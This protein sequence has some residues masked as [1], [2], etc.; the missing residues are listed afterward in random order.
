M[1]T[2]PTLSGFYDYRL[3]ALSVLLAMLASYAALDLAGRITAARGSVRSVWRASGAVAMGLGIWSMHYIGM[4]AYSLPV[5][6]LYDWPTVLISL[7]AAIFASYVALGIVSKDKTSA[8]QYT[9]S[10]VLM[11]TGI[12]AMH[13]IGMEAMR[14][15]AMCQYS[16][17]L[18]ILSVALAIGISLAALWLTSRSRRETDSTGWRK[19]LSAI[20]MGAAIPVMHYT[21][22]AAAT[23]VPAAMSGSVAH[24]VEISS[25][26]IVVISSFTTIVLGLTILTSVVDRRFSEQ[27]SKLQQSEERL[28]LTLRSSGVAVWSWD[29][30]SNILIGDENCAIQFGLALGQFPQNIEGF[31]AL[32]H[33]D[34]RERVQQEAAEMIRSGAEYN[35]EFRAIWPDGSVR[36]LVTRGKVYAGEDGQ[37]RRLMGV[38]WDVTERRKA[39]ESLRA[40]SQRL[41]AE[42]KF[43][44]L[45]EAAPDAVVVVDRAGKIVLVNSQ[46]EKLFGYARAELLGQALEMLVPARFRDGHPKHRGE[47]FADPHVRAMGAG[48]ELYALRKDG[49]EFPVE[50]SLSPLETGDG[51]LVSSTIRD[52]TERKRVERGRDQLASIVDYS[53]DAIIG[54]S[55]EGTIIN[56][57]K[58]A[59]RLYGYS[60]AEAVGKPIAILLPPDRA[61]E[62][63]EIISKLQRGEIVSEETV[64]RRKD[65]TLINVALTVSPIKDSSGRVT[66]A[67]AIARDISERK[68]AD[69][70][71]R[72]L[73]EA[74][75][76]PVVV[77]NG[78]GKIV[79]VNTQ[80]ER[81]F[82]YGREELLGRPIEMLVPA[83]FRG[84]H[85]KHRGEFF[86]DPHVRAMGAGVELYALR[87]DGLEFPVEIS[88]SPLETEE[89]VL[90]SSSIRDITERRA[91]ED[92]LRRS[93]AILQGVFESLPG[94][95]LILTPD[96]QIVSASDAYLKAT[97][98]ERE[99]LCGRG[100]FEV[101]PDNPDDTEAT[102]V[103]NLR[104]SLARVLQTAAPDTMA[105]QK[106]DIRRPDGVFEERYWSPIN[107][108]VFGTGHRIEYLIHRVEDVTDFVRQKS[109]PAS[110]TAD[111]R[112]RMQQ[113]E[114]EIFQNSQHLQAANQQLH[115]TIAQL[116]QAK[117]AAEAADRAKST[118]LSTMSHEIRTPMNAIL[119]Y[120][121]LMQRDPS[122]GADAR[123]NLQIIGRSGEHLL[124]L[125]NDVLDMSRIEAGRIDLKPSTFNL[126]RLLDDLAAM[127]RPRAQAKALRFEMS[128]D[129]EVAP[130]VVA[131]EGK[132]RQALINLAGNAIKFT[133]RGQ[134]TLHVTLDPRMGG[135]LWLVARIEDTGPGISKDDQETLFEPFSQVKRELNAQEGTGLGLAITRKYARLMGGDISLTSNPGAGS[136]FR[137]E[138]PVGRGEA[139][140]AIRR[141]AHRRVRGLHAGMTAPKILVVDDQL[142]N[143]DWLMKLLTFIGFSVQSANNGRAAIRAWEE[144]KP[145][146]ILMDIHM[147]VMGGLE[148]TR[149]IKANPGGK[150]TAIVALTA[151]ALDEDR[152]SVSE[153]GADDFLAKP[154]R[155]EELLEKMRVL[156]GLAYDY[157]DT[158]ETEGQSADG[159][160]ALS[161]ERLALLPLQLVEELR[162]ATVNGNKNLLDKLILKIPDTGDAASASALQQLA[163][164]YDYD[165]LTR[166]LEEA[167]R[168]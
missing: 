19:L 164:K 121:Q 122:L 38:T 165:T 42:G 100:L 110:D 81:L 58:G 160:S 90:V 31:T 40:L 20:V 145:R 32:I 101:F 36:V 83:R 128:V 33:L 27:G 43:R 77:V 70:K 54:K 44:E 66:A 119:G 129:G 152:R 105:I 61:D 141:Q 163:N 22:M 130:Y 133:E 18:V 97:M 102:G 30:A 91:V 23:F 9:T 64:R 76:D 49:S 155:E 35:T 159:A 139:G 80:V 65:G 34:D 63:H 10:A 118:F 78:E 111:L 148:A 126:L 59:E 142:E 136:V 50:I 7:L 87:K 99:D 79:L 53:N 67:S 114:A 167:C 166:L 69:A 158:G 88:L 82:G 84:G 117:A 6:V 72:G 112:R 62:L 124:T 138:I 51:A 39:E 115:D 47:F 95:F 98:T 5:A 15:P 25:L 137:F 92:E 94:L 123:A 24:A 162:N 149:R 140:V 104:A 135:Q 46:V 3:V 168:R 116:Q 28:R 14:L 146:L 125:I 8:R 45:L 55:L 41:V 134:V 60:A 37:P 103:S 21:G 74:A 2:E 107:S 108:P 71:F 13:Y 151:S 17:P 57:N 52:I 93:R 1:P 131:D 73:L 132:V 75:P 29:I 12:A 96:L 11:G 150:E 153:S 26:G 85:P 127:F 154:C 113:M 56:W 109:Q 120:A 144:W 161:A 106:Y 86:A 16:A 143:R 48:A 89:G 68:R 156:L 147:P 157:E 4:L